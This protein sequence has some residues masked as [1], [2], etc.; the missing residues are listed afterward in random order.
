VYGFNYGPGYSVYG[1][2]YNTS[3]IGVRGINTVA[4]NYGDLGTQYY[5]IYGTHASGNWGLIGSSSVGIYGENITSGNYGYIGMSNYG[6]YGY[7]A[8][9]AVGNYAMYG[10]GPHS[11]G[12]NGTGYGVSSTLGGVKGYCYYG[13]PYTFGVAGYSYL[14]Y[15]RSGGCF[16]S[17]NTGT[18]WGAM[19]YRSDTGANYGGYFTSLYVVPG[20]R[21]NTT[22]TATNIGLG[23][24]GDL[25]G[26]D[27]HGRV[28]GLYAEG[29]NYA[30]FSNGV[31]FKNNLDVHLQ[32]T[33]SNT[34]S[35]L[36]TNV[37]TDV[38]VQTSGFS[39]LNKGEALIEFDDNFKK[40]VSSEIPIVVSVTP[41][42][43]CQGVYVASVDR[44]GFRILESNRGESS[45]QVSFIAIGRRAGYERPQLPSEVI[46]S[47][48][49]DKLSRGFHNDAD[50]QTS[51]EG[52]YYENGQLVVGRHPSTLP[53]AKP[54]QDPDL[55]QAPV[56]EKS[57]PDVPQGDG[58]APDTEQ[59]KSQQK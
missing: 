21:A 8:S 9:T 24:W 17:N 58:A 25:F 10:Y 56:P 18:T 59:K 1:I 51:G 50:T 26:A 22:G 14:D 40:V 30:S 38:T 35:I 19:G 16:G 47:D 37:S 52:L 55:I 29:N 28:Y 4:N 42:G 48:Y 15:S 12:V 31:T 23:A 44:N 5:G 57:R 33:Q 3:G 34:M 27:I 32:D 46:A 54:A 13:N 36:Y 53:Q 6:V 41:M 11:S 45:V 43:E 49:V 2:N 39:K 7:L 20:D